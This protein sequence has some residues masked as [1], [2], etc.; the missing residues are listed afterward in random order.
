MFTYFK[1]DSIRKLVV[2][3]GNIFNNIQIQQLNADNTNRIFTIPLSYAAKE[4]FI[5]RL[6]EPSSI[7]DNTRVE[8]SLPRMAFE[9]ASLSYDSIRRMN[10]I[11]K[12][13][14]TDLNSASITQS[15]FTET[16]YNFIFNL[17]V[18]TR[19]IEENLEIIEQILPYFGPEFIISVNM[20]SLNTSVDIPI[21]I[22]QT[23]LTQEYEGDMGSRRF[24]VSSLQFIAKSYLYANTKSD[25]NISGF[26]GSG[27]WMGDLEYNG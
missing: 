16:P 8:I 1:N 10:K 14:Y 17:Y 21:L 20:N 15:S 3:F 22:S 13:T 6:Q 19:N 27:D 2:A 23:S 7:S 12:K 4:K 18:Y 9:L 24:I 5:K 11:S 26:T 25:T